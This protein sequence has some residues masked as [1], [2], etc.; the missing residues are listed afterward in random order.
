[1]VMA[2][3]RSWAVPEAGEINV[4]EFTSRCICSGN[5]LDPG[6]PAGT[7]AICFSLPTNGILNYGKVRTRLAL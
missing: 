5:W 7:S 2:I 6:Q 1:M 4:M 3:V